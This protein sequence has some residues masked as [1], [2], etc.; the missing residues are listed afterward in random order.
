[1]ALFQVDILLLY[2]WPLYAMGMWQEAGTCLIFC[3]VSLLAMVETPS[4]QQIAVYHTKVLPYKGI[5]VKGI[6]HTK[7]LLNK[8]IIWN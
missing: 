2:A 8:G 7:V 4:P 6:T 3:Q 5:I 1:M